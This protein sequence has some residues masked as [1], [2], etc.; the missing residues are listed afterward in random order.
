[1]TIDAV[2][3]VPVGQSAFLEFADG[4]VTG[5]AGCN[6]LNGPATIG[7]D[8]ITFGPIVTTRRACPDAQ[9]LETH[10]LEVL[11]GEVAYEID[12]DQAR[13]THTSGTGLECVRV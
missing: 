6:Q 4:Q 9:A 7:E 12:G 1:M 5:N 2:A 11:T 13:L 10:I 3:S 8:T